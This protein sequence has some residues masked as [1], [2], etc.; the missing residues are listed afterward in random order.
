MTKPLLI[1]VLCVILILLVHGIHASLIASSEIKY[2][3]RRKSSFEP[4][5]KNGDPCEK[6]FLISLAVRSGQV[7]V[8]GQIY[9]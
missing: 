6:K 3:T 8:Y 1:N 2:C 7:N 9:A 5:L 4:M